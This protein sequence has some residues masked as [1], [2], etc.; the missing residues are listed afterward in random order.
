MLQESVG[1]CAARACAWLTDF[2]YR[3]GLKGSL[4]VCLYD[5][6]VVHCPV[7]ERQVWW[8]AV[9]LFMYLRNGY[10]YEGRILRYP[11]D[12]EYN[13]GWS[14]KPDRETLAKLQDP[15]WN[16]TPEHLRMTENWLDQMCE[17]CEANPR[18]ALH[19]QYEVEY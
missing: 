16:P 19:G 11:V 10:E 8:K 7:E 4:I 2:K 12:E 18:L 15:T 9:K 13:A 3:I 6:C 1:S 5:S 14:T 17:L